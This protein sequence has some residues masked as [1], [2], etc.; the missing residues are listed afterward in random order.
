MHRT[1]LV[2]LEPVVREFEL[3]SFAWLDDEATDGTTYL[4]WTALKGLETPGGI[5][6]SV[7]NGP[8]VE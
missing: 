6:S 5:P 8:G 1:D 4:D 2:L 3:L 7:V